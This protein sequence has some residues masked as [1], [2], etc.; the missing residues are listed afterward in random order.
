[1]TFQYLD[2]GTDREHI[3]RGIR[4]DTCL[5]MSS[6]LGNSGQ[7]SPFTLSIIAQEWWMKA[8][9]QYLQKPKL[10]F[11]EKTFI[12][13]FKCLHACIGNAPSNCTELKTCITSSVILVWSYSNSPSILISI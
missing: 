8:T 13:C 11:R 7:L 12:F 10:E 3:G 6:I 1:M 4:C 5:I 9:N 2:Q